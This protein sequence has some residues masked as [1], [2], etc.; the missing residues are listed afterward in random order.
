MSSGQDQTTVWKALGL[1][2]SASSDDEDTVVSTSQ[3]S[4]MTGMNASSTNSCVGGVHQ[5]WKESNDCRTVTENAQNYIGSCSGNLK[6]GSYKNANAFSRFDRIVNRKADNCTSTCQSRIKSVFREIGNSCHENSYNM[7]LTAHDE[8]D[9]MGNKLINL[10]KDMGIY[11]DDDDEDDDYS[12]SSSETTYHP[13]KDNDKLKPV[14]V[15]RRNEKLDRMSN[16]R[17]SERLTKL[18]LD[19]DTKYAQVKLIHAGEE[20]ENE[21]NEKTK[22]HTYVL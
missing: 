12:D 8:L 10:V 16:A 1:I 6:K 15:R 4:E 18:N 3:R 11:D 13:T 7:S 2:L 20:N 5:Q 21:M 9:K 17:N 19:N 14:W 22:Q